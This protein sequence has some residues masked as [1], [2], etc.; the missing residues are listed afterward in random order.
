MVDGLSLA[1]PACPEETEYRYQPVWE[2]KEPPVRFHKAEVAT[3]G[4]MLPSRR[5][6]VD[7]GDNGHGESKMR[8]KTSFCAVMKVT[9]SDGIFGRLIHH[10][11]QIDSL[12][13]VLGTLRQ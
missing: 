10:P 12:R 8:L 9:L 4:H 13:P 6:D 5:H 2:A 1:W 11:N 7:G 3:T